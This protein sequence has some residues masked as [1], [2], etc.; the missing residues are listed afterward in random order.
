MTYPDGTPIR[1]RKRKG[2]RY[3]V[4]SIHMYGMSVSNRRDDVECV[5]LSQFRTMKYC[6]FDAMP[7]HNARLSPMNV[8]E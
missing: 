7:V 8:N 1:K 4:L 3:G 5:P 2:T 6:M